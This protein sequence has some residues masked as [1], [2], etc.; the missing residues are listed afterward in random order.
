MAT[1][2]TLEILT[3]IIISIIS[4]CSQPITL[5]SVLMILDRQVTESHIKD[6]HEC[7]SI[8]STCWLMIGLYLGVPK[9]K[10][11]EIEIDCPNVNSKLIE[12]ISTW[13]SAGKNCTWK[14][15][16]IALHHCK[17]IEAAKPVV[18]KALD[19]ALEYEKP[20][21]S[22]KNYWEEKETLRQE[23]VDSL[24]HRLKEALN[25]QEENMVFL[26][27]ELKVP[28]AISDKFLLSKFDEH[29][30][31]TPY[32]YNIITF[33]SYI[34]N[35]TESYT[36]IRVCLLEWTEVLT[37]DMTVV[38]NKLN[39]LNILKHKPE[40]AIQEKD[41][42]LNI[43][44]AKSYRESLDH[45]L[46]TCLGHTD[47]A[48]NS[49]ENLKF[50]IHS[51]L[52]AFRGTLV[53]LWLLASVTG[54]I[55]TYYSNAYYAAVLTVI[56]V[57]IAYILSLVFPMFVTLILQRQNIR[58]L[59]CSLVGAYYAFI[60]MPSKQYLLQGSM[61]LR[62]IDNVEIPQ[63]FLSLVGGLALGW[64][65][66]VL[67]SSFIYGIRGNIKTTAFVIFITTCLKWES[68]VT[69]NGFAL[70]GILNGIC[71]AWLSR[72][73]FIE[74][75]A[76]LVTI[77]L[78]DIITAN[79]TQVIFFVGIHISWLV[80][81]STAVIAGALITLCLLALVSSVR[82]PFFITNHQM[83]ETLQCL[84][85][86]I[87]ELKK[88]RQDIDEALQFLSQS[89]HVMSDFLQLMNKICYVYKFF[90]IQT[91]KIIFF[92]TVFL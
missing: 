68:L 87:Q 84:T 92:H 89:P 28:I 51:W 46:T 38:C 66:M 35:I 3:P 13:I 37:T 30:K 17:L 59:I 57:S 27:K 63:P 41:N 49:N 36:V 80:T 55:F 52:R 25:S 47:S 22:S 74:Y 83:D 82:Y 11:N 77:H 56:L 76:T 26:R 85:E 48:I 45:E 12:M 58:R 21:S 7:L 50:A 16:C 42:E 19:V 24:K 70:I 71:Y 31:Y 6:V 72:T 44:N 86:N 8:V 65:G 79:T 18:S 62:T 53:T 88:T 67:A 75:L 69:S 73:F 23:K 5:A 10:L 9:P 34:I 20:L 81:I 14:E 2:D 43:C 29:I 39:E 32:V 40:C 54:H 61:K 90:L 91:F 33:G 1:P 60:V 64:A 15:L 78:S 4:E